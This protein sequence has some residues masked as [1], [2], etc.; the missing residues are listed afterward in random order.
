MDKTFE[1]YWEA[2]WI[3]A[4][5]SFGSP[6]PALDAAFKEVAEKA[7]NAATANMLAV[8]QSIRDV[9]TTAGM[10]DTQRVAVMCRLASAAINKATE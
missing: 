4:I 8:L 6:Q 5:G 10:S 2:E 3:P 7:W 9:E 1:K